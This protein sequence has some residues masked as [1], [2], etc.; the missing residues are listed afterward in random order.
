[1]HSAVP[2]TG[3]APSL[4]TDGDD[5]DAAAE[6][7]LPGID[8]GYTLEPDGDVE[9]QTLVPGLLRAAAR[10]RAADARPTA[11]RRAS[12]RARSASPGRPRPTTAGAVAS[13]DVLLDG[14]AARALSRA[15]TRRVI[16][17][18]FHPGAQTVYRVRAVDASGNAGVSSRAIVV[19]PTKRPKDL[20]RA[21]PRWAWDAYTRSAPARAPRR[22]AEEAA[23]LVL[24]L[25]GVA[26][27]A[28]PPEA[29]A[30]RRRAPRRPAPVPG[31]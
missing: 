4:S 12:S 22:G 27:R 28:V 10:H 31:G 25:G 15:A 2:T 19:V 1:M 29:L 23:R 26:R 3:L 14:I 8:A 16:V 9:I 20:P 30:L 17:R 18:A 24:A 5:V 13:Y 11:S 21:L 6:A 7:A